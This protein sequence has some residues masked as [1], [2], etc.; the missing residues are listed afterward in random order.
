MKFMWLQYQ[1]AAATYKVRWGN[2]RTLDVTHITLQAPHRNLPDNFYCCCY[3][4]VLVMTNV[5]P[6]D[7]TMGHAS[8]CQKGSVFL[9]I[10][11]LKRM[12]FQ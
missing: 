4:T 2:V 10:N 3:P 8:V 12:I 5:A 9:A 7:N 6:I 11:N 1:T